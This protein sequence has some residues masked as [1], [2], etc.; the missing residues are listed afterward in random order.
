MNVEDTKSIIEI[1]D[2]TEVNDYLALGW[3][4]INQYN[5]DVGELGQPSQRP[6]YVL[7]WQNSETPA[8]HPEN[9]THLQSQR[10]WERAKKI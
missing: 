8:Q 3:V 9:S 2:A 5:I 1:A 4:L 10:M 6:R 7:A